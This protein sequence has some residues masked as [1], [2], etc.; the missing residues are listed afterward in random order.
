MDVTT[1]RSSSNIQQRVTAGN[2][3]DGDDDTAADIDADDE[4]FDD[5]DD[6]DYEELDTN[7]SSKIYI[8]LFLDRCRMLI[9]SS[10][11]DVEHVVVGAYVIA[12]NYCHHFNCVVV[13]VVVVR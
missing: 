12:M 8:I 10:T 11:W 5:D 13:V 7:K 2:D 1:K 4:F 3:G 9:T 6:I